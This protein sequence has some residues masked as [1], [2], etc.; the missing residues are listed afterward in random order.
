M[1]LICKGEQECKFETYKLGIHSVGSTGNPELISTYVGSGLNSK[2]D[3]LKAVPTYLTI[4][5]SAVG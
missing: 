5:P 3:V 4:L 2:T 1:G